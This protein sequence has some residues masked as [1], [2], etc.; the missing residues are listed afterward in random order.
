[1]GVGPW[2]GCARGARLGRERVGVCEHPPRRNE[3]AAS[4]LALFSLG[5]SGLVGRTELPSPTWF[6]VLSIDFAQGGWAYMIS[7]GVLVLLMTYFSKN[8]I[9]QTQSAT[10]SISALG[11]GLFLVAIALLPLVL[12]RLSGLTAYFLG[13]TGVLILTGVLWDAL[14]SSADGSSVCRCLPH[15]QPSPGA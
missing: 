1:M 7:Y 5:F 11:V 12:T 14:S 2:A 10:P 3:W 8:A 9:F 6:Q 13:G 4:L 15:V